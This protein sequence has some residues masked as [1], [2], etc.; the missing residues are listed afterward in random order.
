MLDPDKQIHASLQ[1]LFDTYRQTHSASMVV[2][3][4]RRE[5]WVFP[6]RILRGIGK[7]EVHW[8]VEHVACPADPAQPQI[9][10]RIRVR[11]NANRAQG[12]FDKY[13]T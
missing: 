2:R 5:G 11:P 12:R 7:G 13:T 1:L 8:G 9:R 4:F 3:R 10:R 6:R